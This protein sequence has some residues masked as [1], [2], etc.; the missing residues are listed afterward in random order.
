MTAR[1]NADRLRREIVARGRDMQNFA[2]LAGI[3]AATLSHAVNG[4]PVV[5]G[6]LR[7]ITSALLR[8]PRLEGADLLLLVDDARAAPP[9]HTVPPACRRR[10]RQRG[11]AVSAA[12]RPAGHRNPPNGHQEP[13]PSHEPWWPAVDGGHQPRLAAASL[14]LPRWRRAHRRGRQ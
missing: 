5:A 10:R 11:I 8:A 7:R 9:T 13:A 4:R 1:I 6:T 12:T 14:R 3:S 2:R